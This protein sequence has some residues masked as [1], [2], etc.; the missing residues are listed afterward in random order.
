MGVPAAV[1]SKPGWA[2]S[3]AE[4]AKLRPRLAK[5]YDLHSLTS[6]STCHR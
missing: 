3:A 4:V 2:P 1:A 6:C 5:E